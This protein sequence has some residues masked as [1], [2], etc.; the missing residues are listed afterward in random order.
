MSHDLELRANGQHSFTAVREPAWHRLGKVYPDA[1]GLTL[2]QVLEDLDVG[3]LVTEPV[4]GRTSGTTMPGK[5]MI[6]RRRHTEQGF[7]YHIPLGVVGE[8]YGVIPEA[9]AFSWTQDLVDIGGAVF[10]TAGL[11]G[12]RGER[13]FASLKFPEGILVGGVDP[14]DL[15]LVTT[16]SHDGEVSLTGMATPVRVVCQNTLTWGLTAARQKWTIRHSRHVDKAMDLTLARANLDLTFAYAGEWA[17]EAEELLKVEMTRLQFE[18]IVA[19][20][21]KPADKPYKTEAARKAVQTTWDL[22]HDALM[23]LWDGPTQDNVRGTAWA[24]AN[25]LTEFTDWHLG[26]RQ[27]EDEIAHRFE[28]S[29]LGGVNVEKDK[30]MK[31]VRAMAGGN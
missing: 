31:V 9:R 14:V 28:R 29:I 12:E 4:Q 21:Y 2:D 22:R 15:Y 10:Q 1:D 5:K 6:S 3:E 17:A 7:P 13:A 16:F 26:T 27:A 11:L 8:N 19:D 30:I 24:G 20:L 23:G 25:A 18:R